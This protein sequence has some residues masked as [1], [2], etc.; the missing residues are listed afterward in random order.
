MPSRHVC[1]DP[2]FVPPTPP[3]APS[4]TPPPFLGAT[5]ACPRQHS[6]ARSTLPP[7]FASAC[8]VRCRV[9][10]PRVLRRVLQRAPTCTTFPS[11]RL[12]GSPFAPAL[13]ARRV[14]ACLLSSARIHSCRAR[15]A[16][17]LRI[18][19]SLARCLCRLGPP[20]T[21]FA[22]SHPIPARYRAV[23]VLSWRTRDCPLFSCAVLC[24]TCASHR[25]PVGQ[26]RPTPRPPISL[27]VRGSAPSF[28]YVRVCGV[29]VRSGIGLGRAY[30]ILGGLC[31]MDRC[32][33][34]AR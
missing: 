6:R 20:V 15:Y 21:T 14:Y 18:A 27:S 13:C 19:C 33:G 24:L 23:I 28:Q 5:P 32:S 29:T 34:R 25:C 30:D 2:T 26:Q 1:Y 16:A 10:H 22:R 3:C 12:P 31:F 4:A 7:L 11:L 17:G 8:R 9:L